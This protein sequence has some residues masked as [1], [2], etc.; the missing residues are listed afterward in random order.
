[1]VSAAPDSTIP[2][3]EAQEDLDALVKLKNIEFDSNKATLTEKGSATVD[4]VATILRRTSAK[5]EIQGHTDDRG[6]EAANLG[7]S[8]RRADTVLQA[9]TDRGVPA[10]QLTAIGKGESEPVVDNETTEG[11]ARNRRIQFVVSAGS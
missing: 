5:V 6:E 2:A 1:M 8:Q 7:L 10:E 11:R 4:E 9:L 3:V